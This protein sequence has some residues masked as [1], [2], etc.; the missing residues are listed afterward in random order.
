[1]LT[2]PFGAKVPRVLADSVL[3][4]SFRSL[5]VLGRNE[6]CLQWIRHWVCFRNNYVLNTELC[7]DLLVPFCF[8]FQEKKKK[9]HCIRNC[10]TFF[11]FCL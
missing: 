1:M 11:K 10:R 6:D 5:V 3:C 9:K 2:D 7:F 4:S 8:L